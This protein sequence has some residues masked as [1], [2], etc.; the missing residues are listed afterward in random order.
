MLTKKDAEQLV[1]LYNDC[2]D[3]IMRGAGNEFKIGDAFGQTAGLERALEACGYVFVKKD[4][5]GQV[6]GI[7][8]AH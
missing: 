4:G 7:E 5:S 1:K 8:K 2:I 3:T 6:C